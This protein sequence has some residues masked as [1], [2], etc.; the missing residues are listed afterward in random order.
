MILL[1]GAINLFCFFGDWN[2]NTG[3]FFGKKND[4]E[5]MKIP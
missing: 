5:K 3:V 1:Y 2:I 4:D